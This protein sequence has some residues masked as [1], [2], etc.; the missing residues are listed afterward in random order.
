MGVGE[1][2][3][4]SVGV[5]LIMGVGESVGVRLNVGE[6]GKKDV[7]VDEYGLVEGVGGVVVGEDD[8]TDVRNVDE[9]RSGVGV[10]EDGSM[11]V[12]NEDECRVSG[13]CTG[14]FLGV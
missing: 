11:D 9:Y 1:G 7:N 8:T 6:D 12:N 10:G 3:G 4:V 14:K 2:V 13:A 5:C